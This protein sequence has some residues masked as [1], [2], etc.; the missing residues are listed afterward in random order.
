M[1]KIPVLNVSVNGPENEQEKIAYLTTL[2]EL[3][4]AVVLY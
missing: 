2:M 4:V 1:M 3:N